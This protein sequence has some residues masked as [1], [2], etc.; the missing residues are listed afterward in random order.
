LI[1]Y[2][3]AD[4]TY[5]VLGPLPNKDDFSDEIKL[6]FPY[7]DTCGPRVFDDKT[8]FDLGFM[9][10]PKR[11]FRSAPYVDSNKAYLEWLDRVEKK[12]R[13]LERVWNVQLNPAL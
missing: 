8:K 3:L 7:Q 13:V 4:K 2:Q 11:G 6:F 9:K 10:Q 12:T 5:A 1:L